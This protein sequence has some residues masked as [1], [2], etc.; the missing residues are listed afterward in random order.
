[1][2]RRTPSRSTPRPLWRLA[3]AALAGTAPMQAPCLAQDAS[4][5]SS[6]ERYELS[7]DGWRPVDPEG[8]DPRSAVG[9]LA[10]IRERL[11]RSLEA[12]ESGDADTARDLAE[13]AVE[14]GESW[15]SDFPRTGLEAEARLLLGDA[16]AASDDLYRALRDYEIVSAG[17][18]G[19]EQFIDALWRQYEIAVRLVTGDEIVPVLVVFRTTGRKLGEE[20]LIRIQERAPGSAVGEEAMFALADY[21][22]ARRDMEQAAVAYDLFLANYPRSPRREWALLRLINAS[23]GRFRGPR[24]DATVLIEANERILQYEREFPATADRVSGFRLRIREALAERDYLTGGWFETRG[25]DVS[26]AVLY[27]AVVLDFPETVAARRALA[28]LSALDVDIA[29]LDPPTSN[30]LAA[31]PALRPGPDDAAPG[32]TAPPSDAPQREDLSP[33]VSPDLDRLP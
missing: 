27:R 3:L 1:M 2:R 17:F 21:Y 22:Y 24:F 31:L 11:A 15:M 25:K 10:A 5:P 28:R 7:A 32:G 16:K 23:L 12:R 6:L 14:M 29:R 33:P 8:A 26:A 9:R 19:S 18:P 30:S 13:E 4:G 20:L